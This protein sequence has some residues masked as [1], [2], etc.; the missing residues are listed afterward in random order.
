MQ[1][2]KDV[3]VSKVIDQFDKEPTNFTRE[4]KF[5]AFLLCKNLSD[6]CQTAIRILKGISKKGIPLT[7]LPDISS[8]SICDE[9]LCSY[10]S[11]SMFI[12]NDEIGWAPVWKEVLKF[13]G[14]KTEVACKLYRA[15]SKNITSGS[16]ARDIQQAVQKRD[17]EFFIKNFD[18]IFKNI[19]FTEELKL[20]KNFVSSP[21]VKKEDQEYVWDFFDSLLDIFISEKDNLD[22]LKSL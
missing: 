3:V 8:I 19:P 2:M 20:V 4:K 11:E 16:Q 5:L 10:F 14:N 13:P 12:E 1:Y 22:V 18:E 9:T 6:L 17:K 7:G 15:I 21:H